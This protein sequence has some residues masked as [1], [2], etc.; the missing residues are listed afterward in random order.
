MARL[1]TYKILPQVENLFSAK[2][3]G[4]IQMLLIKPARFFTGT[5]AFRKDNI[6]GHDDTKQ[7]MKCVGKQK[8]EKCKGEAES[9]GEMYR[10]LIP[11]SFC[12]LGLTL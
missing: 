7:H 10:G 5:D 2:H 12:K 8:L 3:A 9:K 4:I 1:G 11:S 6:Q